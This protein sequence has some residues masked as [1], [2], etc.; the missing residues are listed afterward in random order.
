M[1]SGQL[2][3]MVNRR[4][5]FSD[6]LGNPEMLNEAEGCCGALRPT[7]SHSTYSI[8][9]AICPSLRGRKAVIY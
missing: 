5:R 1:D 2:E 7:A 6:E 8:H 3:V 4:N 9:L